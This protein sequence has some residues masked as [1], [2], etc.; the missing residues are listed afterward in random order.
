VT[1]LIV[2]GWHDRRQPAA[3]GIREFFDST[4]SVAIVLRR[5]ESPYN[6]PPMSKGLWKGADPPKDVWRGTDTVDVD[7]RL[8]RRIT[9][10]TR[11]ARK[12]PMIRGEAIVMTSS[13]RD[14]RHAAA[15]PGSGEQVIYYARTTIT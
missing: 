3:R 9:D 8:G 10:W 6:S 4:G 14:G 7:M 13:D 15:C 12:S 11:S 1:A 2:G 5:S